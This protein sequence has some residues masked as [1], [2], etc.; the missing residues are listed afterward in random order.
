MPVD[1]RSATSRVLNPINYVPRPTPV[2]VGQSPTAGP[3]ADSGTGEI[4]TLLTLP[5]QRRSRQ[6]SPTSPIVE[7]SPH[8]PP[9]AGLRTSIGLPSTQRRSIPS[10]P[11]ATS[12]MVEQEKSESRGVSEPGRVHIPTS[13][14]NSRERDLEAQ[15]PSV[16]G[17]NYGVN[18][19]DQPLHPPRRIAS[20]PSL[21]HTQ[22]AAS[23][24]SS[25]YART[26]HDPT[27]A[28]PQYDGAYHPTEGDNDVAEELAWGPSHPCFPHMNPHVPLNSPEY[29]STRIVRI[30]RDWMVVGDL[31]PTYSNIYPEILD[32]LMPEQEFRYIIQHINQ[33]LVHAFDPFATWNWID[34]LLGLVTGW[35]W[36]DFRPIG[37]KGQLRELDTWI[38]E[39]NG[40]VGARDGVKIISLRRT[41]FMNLDIQIPDPQVRV[42]GEGDAESQARLDTANGEE[43]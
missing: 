40:K 3:A 37:V 2:R 5:E 22:S 11:E 29:A 15:S 33:T 32:P 39:W 28:G 14:Y 12:A 17:Q 23:L 21:R 7:H 36:E 13:R 8:L 41:G 16:L 34:G 35:F 19:L 9:E 20:H 27:A 31:A 1:N 10:A 26:T 25:A 42:V 30:R 4:S 38:Q 18:P 6:H 43:K 24:H